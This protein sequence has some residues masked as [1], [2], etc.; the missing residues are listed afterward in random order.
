MESDNSRHCTL[1]RIRILAH[2]W[3]HV[4]AKTPLELTKLMRCLLY[5]TDVHDDVQMA[6]R[7]TGRCTG[8][9]RRP[10]RMS[11]VYADMESLQGSSK[12]AP[13]VLCV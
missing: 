11:E 1:L 10:K 9:A 4:I 7:H 13:H 5:T 2:E 3:L 12:R 6:C 8:G